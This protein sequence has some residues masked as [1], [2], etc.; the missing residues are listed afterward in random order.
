MIQLSDRSSLELPTYKAAHQVED[1][2]PLYLSRSKFVFVFDL[3]PCKSKTTKTLHVGNYVFGR[4]SKQ[5]VAFPSSLL[6]FS[7][8]QIVD[9]SSTGLHKLCH[10]TI[11]DGS[12][13]S[14][15]GARGEHGD[16]FLF[17]NLG[18]LGFSENLIRYSLH[19]CLREVKNNLFSFRHS[20]LR[21][22]S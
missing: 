3:Q 5:N 2:T 15:F 10:P 19:V 7:P 12:T 9:T 17:S 13:W 22:F 14:K 8:D 1:T 6:G 18:A 21:H 20:Y 16:V 11:R 4:K